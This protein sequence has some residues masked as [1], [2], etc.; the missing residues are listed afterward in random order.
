[1]RIWGYIVFIIGI[2]FVILF[3]LAKMGG[4]HMSPL[5]F[6][7][8]LFLIAAGIK[9]IK[10]GKGILLSKTTPRSLSISEESFTKKMPM[11][12]EIS[13]IIDEQCAKN[14]KII[15]YLAIGYILFFFL[16]GGILGFVDKKP[17]EGISLA[18]LFGLLG[19]FVS[20]IV[21]GAFWL[22]SRRPLKKDLQENC[23]LRTKG[24]IQMIPFYGSGILRL[25]DRAFLI[26][27]NYGI[28]ELSKINEGT[29]DYTAHA[30]VILAAW[31][32][33]GQQVYCAKDYRID[34][35]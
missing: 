14:W 10:S 28:K 33:T 19:I 22:I 11:S 17:Q 5:P 34:L 9:L 20:L 4:G 26:N 32:K 25:A 27:G 1:M 2:I 8:A 18:I 12:H 29:V 24:P 13:M 21:V 23:Y 30:H 16:L 7:I 35:G 3:I 31:N 6:I 15:R